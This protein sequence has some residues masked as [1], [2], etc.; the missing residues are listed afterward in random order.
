MSSRYA[1][2]GLKIEK[3]ADGLVFKLY[4]VNHRRRVLCY[5]QGTKDP[6]TSLEYDK[7]VA[8]ITDEREKGRI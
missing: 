3:T 6:P 5:E 1:A 8:A 7:L 4:R 2:P